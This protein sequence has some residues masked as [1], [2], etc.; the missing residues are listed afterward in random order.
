[1]ADDTPSSEPTP[2]QELEAGGRALGGRPSYSWLQQNRSLALGV[3]C[4]LLCGV[5]AVDIVFMLKSDAKRS[6]A[7]PPTASVPAPS[8]AG[9]ASATPLSAPSNGSAGSDEPG[10]DSGA[11]MDYESDDGEPHPSKPAAPKRY[12]TVQHAAV[13]SCTTASVDGLSRQI[14]AQARCIRPNAFVPLPSRPNL[15]IQSQVF[16]YLELEAKNQLVKA[17]DAN[18]KIKMTV[19]SA[20]RT[21]AQQYLVW[22]WSATKRCG[23]PLATP[24]GESNHEIGIALDIAEA[25]AWRG[26]LEAQKFKWLG[27]SDRVH[28]D[29]KGGSAAGR[30]S[31]DVL[32]FQKLWNKNNPKDKIPE[33]GRYSPA[34][35]QRLKQAPADGFAQ[36]PSCTKK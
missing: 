5:I 10:D 26:P 33:D 7:A 34:T 27:A 30:T 24:P 29:Y 15:V 20:L 13:E 8:I 6:A 1:M 17:L 28:F 32:A 9:P 16:P 21:V 35:E 25:A 4:V 18:P 22:R 14:I 11:A 31:T 3:G 12:D 23:V 36:G 2:E 19:N